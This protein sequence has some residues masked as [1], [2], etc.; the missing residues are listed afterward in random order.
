MDLREFEILW[1]TERTYWWFVGQRY[2][3]SSFIRK[4]VRGKILD[5]GCGAGLN[6][7]LL[8]KYGNA[9]GLDV[10]DQALAFCSKRGL[11]AVKSDIM[12]IKL[13]SGSFDVV[14][15]L[16]VF[17]HKGITD[18][19]E[20][21]KQVHKVLK[22]GGRFFL[23][24]CA[25]KSLFGKHDIAFHGARRYTKKELKVKL[26]KAG[27]TVERISYYNTTLFPL[28]WLHRQWGK[29]VNSTPKSEVQE[30]INPVVN[31]ILKKFYLFELSLLKH[32]NLP[33]GVNIMAVARKDS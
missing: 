13:K 26:E 4:Q 32:F 14:T 7:K 3:L 16:G 30:D 27:F 10:S 2:L 18:D 12:D 1:N 21:F 9:L 5:V 28:V 29:L 6:L 23:L 20:G 24:D 11:K 8:G 33:F 31:R 19:V 17:Y 22:K 15:A 25:S